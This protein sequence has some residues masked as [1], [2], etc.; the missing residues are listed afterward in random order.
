MIGCVLLS[1]LPKRG[2]LAKGISHVSGLLF[3]SGGLT[4]MN[5]RGPLNIANLI[6][7]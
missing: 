6:S 3:E 5:T 2:Q 7:A 4:I 1:V